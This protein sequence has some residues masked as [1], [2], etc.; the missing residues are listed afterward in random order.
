MSMADEE[1]D[2]LREE[3]M[4]RMLGETPEDAP[5]GGD[6]NEKPKAKKE[7]NSKRALS[8]EEVDA[9]ITFATEMALGELE[10]IMT[11]I[12]E[13][14]DEMEDMAIVDDISPLITVVSNGLKSLADILMDNVDV[15]KLT[16][17]GKRDYKQAQRIRA[18]ILARVHNKYKKEE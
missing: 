7:D 6:Q 14:E 2:E 15:G 18:H 12:R 4:K 10:R 9:D 8:P 5:K 1:R 17:Q 16:P 13:L 3:V 11:K